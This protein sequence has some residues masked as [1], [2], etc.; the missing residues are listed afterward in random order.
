MSYIQEEWKPVVGFE[1]LYE[2]SSFGKIRGISRVTKRPRAPLS[3]YDRKADYHRVRVWLNRKKVAT[4]TVHIAVMAAFVGPRPPGMVINHID[5]D[6]WNNTVSNLEYVTPA[7]NT[8]HAIRSGLSPHSTPQ[9]IARIFLAAIRLSFPVEAW[10]IA[11]AITATV[12]GVDLSR[13]KL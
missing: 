12:A 10:P 13:H 3:P 1:G 4:I 7:E 5:G 6:K 11:I 9:D 2:V 8:W